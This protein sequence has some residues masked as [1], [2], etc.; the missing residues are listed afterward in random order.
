MGMTLSYPRILGWISCALS[1]LISSWFQVAI[2]TSQAP[3]IVLIISDD[4]A[5][6]DY[7]F[8]G[9]EIIQTPHLDRL[10]SQSVWFDRGYVPTAL[11]R[12][13]LMTLATGHYAH[14]HGVTGNDPSP[15]YAP[16]GS[17]IEQQRRAELISFLNQFDSLPAALARSGYLTHQSGKW[18][19]GSFAQGGFTHGMTRGFPEPGGRH[20][21]DGLTIGRE[22]LGPIREFVDHAMTSEQPFFL[23]YAP[24]LPHT[25]HNPPER[26]LNRYRD[27][28]DSLQVAKYYAMCT[29][30]DE[31]CG[32]LLELI[33]EKGIREN[34]LVIYVTD[35]GWIQHPEKNGYAPRSKQTPYEGGIRTPIMFRWPGQFK[36][37]HRSELVSSIDLYPTILS[38]AGL[39]LPNGLPGLDL[40]QSMRGS[41]PL[42][43]KQLFGEGFA[44][45]IADI[46]KPEASLLYRWTIQ[47]RWKLLLTYDGEVNRYQSSHPRD[48]HGPQLFDLESDPHERHNLADQ[49]PAK[50]RL[51]AESLANWYP[52]KE[53]KTLAPLP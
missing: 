3:N 20:G 22:G 6:T 24:F 53:R 36:A 34:T 21:D 44:H 29:W 52:L 23:W 40:V 45:D 19:E 41:L 11:C 43:R 42:A 38:A 4:Q 25:P 39:P 1:L 30:F 10:A 26:L 51:L 12:P 46:N 35:N 49:Q 14:R 47:G 31:T 7:G 15:K 17:K 18:W 9:H 27:K 37:S 28:V 50:V 13:S 32:S 5:W 48:I 33:D 2:A 8:M 16:Q